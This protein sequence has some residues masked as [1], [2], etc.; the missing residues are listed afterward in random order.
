M[1]NLTKLGAVSVAASLLATTAFAEGLERFNLST[2]FMFEEGTYVEASYAQITPELPATGFNL[3]GGNIL[4]DTDVGEDF[5]AVGASFKTDITERLSVGLTF[6]NQLAGA[7]INWGVV[8]IAAD[9]QVTGLTFLGKYQ[10]NENISLLGG[11]KRAELKDSTLALPLG[12]SNTESWSSSG[13]DAGYGYVIGAAYE[14]PEIALR[15]V[16]TYEGEV[17]IDPDLTE[18][19]PASPVTAAADGEAD[20]S[21]GDAWNLYFQTGVAQN[22]LAFANIR[23]SMWEDN[24][25]FVPTAGGLAQIT[26]FEDGYSYSLGVAQR[27]SDQWA[28]SASIFYDPG[29]GEDASPLSPVGANRSLTLGA[30]YTMPQG[31]DISFGV[32]FSKRDD[33]T[34]DL[35]GSGTP[36]DTPVDAV[37]EGSTVTTLGVRVGFSF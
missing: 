4:D 23:Y 21:I 11:I 10:V 2:G 35:D 6:T 12:V 3:G 8:G 16:L 29:D 15:A 24:Q 14:I 30:R 17:Q 25:G 9:V 31:A 33:A 36:G 1:N 13:G 28:L 20:L 34:I 27:L 22:T 5:N 7:N 26:T 19:D 37:V 18:T 32:S